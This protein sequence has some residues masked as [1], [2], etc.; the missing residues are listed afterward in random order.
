MPIALI[1]FS[2]PAPAEI[3]SHIIDALRA[4]DPDEAVKKGMELLMQIEAAETMVY[5]RVDAEGQLQ[6]QCVLGRRASDLESV[7]NESNGLFAE[8][9][10]AQKSALLVMGQA[11]ADEESDL[12]RGVV[13]FLL[14]GASE[15]STGFNYI[16]PLSSQRDGCVLG[17]L[18]LLRSAADGPLNHEQPNICEAMR[19]ELSDILSS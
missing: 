19:L 5:E 4:M 17:A 1:P 14:D 2:M 13:D 11:S 10:I 16:L 18:T 7:L 9:I 8:A 6:L 12:P 15:G 3:P